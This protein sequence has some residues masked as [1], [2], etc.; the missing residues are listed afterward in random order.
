[1]K[2]TYSSTGCFVDSEQVFSLLRKSALTAS[3]S[4]SPSTSRADSKRG[5]PD[6]AKTCVSGSEFLSSDSK[7]DTSPDIRFI[8]IGS[9]QQDHGTETG[10]MDF[11]PT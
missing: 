3:A 4:P 5:P 9:Y 11:L 10:E 1:M 8:R 7:Y 6:N 2:L